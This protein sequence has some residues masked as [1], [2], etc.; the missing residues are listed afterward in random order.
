MQN[1]KNLILAVLLSSAIM[2]L[3]NVFYV[4]PKIDEHKRKQEAYEATQKKNN[5]E[6]EK[7]LEKPEVLL[8]RV[9]A[10]KV[11]KNRRIKINSNKLHGSL[12]LKGARIDDLT[13]GQFKQSL[14]KNSPEVELLSPSS[15]KKPYYA[16]FGWLAS[17]GVKVP[18][19]NT[20]WFSD[21]KV[22]TPQKAVTL[23]WDNNQGLKFTTVIAMDENYLFTFN[24]TVENYGDKPVDLNSYGM[25]NRSRSLDKKSFYI[26]H[27]GALGVFQDQLYEEKFDSIRKKKRISYED[28]NGWLGITDKYWLTAIIPDQNNFFDVKFNYYNK[29]GLSRFQVDYLGEKTQITAG[30]KMQV[31]DNL[32]AGAKKVSLLDEYNTKLDIKLF[33]R[34][35]DFGMLYFMTKPIFKVLSFFY[36]LLGNFGLAILALTISIKLLLFPLVNKSYVSMHKMKMIHPE[37]VEIKER[38]KD[39]KKQANKEI[40]ELYKKKGINPVSGCLPMLLQL[41]VFFALYKVLFVTI[42]MRHAPFYGWISDLSAPDPTNIFNLFGLLNFDL[43]FA[44]SAW[45]IIM[46]LTMFAQQKLSPPPSDPIQAK[47]MAFLPLIVV[48]MTATFPAGLLIYWSWSN[49][50]SFIQQ[51][52][53]KLKFK[54]LDKKP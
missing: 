28:V 20:V 9:D 51:L 6:I 47:V 11:Q 27:E 13:L 33:D 52:I 7:E 42:E 19:S 34:S 45:S 14:A 46:G 44:I 50:L 8:D 26:L 22:L 5:P 2:I 17:A 35:V 24:R 1:S 30:A 39:D 31:T 37:M 16:E 25:I 29:N 49:S 15:A 23:T 3:W 32:F 38:Y 54:K 21:D 12:S 18:N 43:P 53:I 48:V 41:P 40:M 36:E 10:I 4:K